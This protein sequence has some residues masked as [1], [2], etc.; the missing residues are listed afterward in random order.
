MFF[1]VRTQLDSVDFSP[2]WGHLRKLKEGFLCKVQGPSW[3]VRAV[4][5]GVTAVVRVVAVAVRAV[6][7]VVMTAVIVTVMMTR[8]VRLM[9]IVNRKIKTMMNVSIDVRYPESDV[10]H[11]NDHLHC[12]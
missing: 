9:E 7:L 6:M 8:V 12:V 2:L 3:P 1:Q 4:K 10:D 11:L 5:V